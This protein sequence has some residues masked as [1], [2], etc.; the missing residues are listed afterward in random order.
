MGL[1]STTIPNLVNGVS[2]Q[3]YA[4]RLASQCERLVNGYPSVVE[5]LGKRPGSRY[6]GT[7]SSFNSDPFLHLIN[8]DKTEKY[9]VAIADGDL[10]VF[11]LQGTEK[12]VNFPDGKVY[13]TSANAV[14]GLKCMTV[15]DYTFVLNTAI[16]VRASTTLSPTRPY[17]ALVWIK[18]GAYGATYTLTVAGKAVSYKVPDGSNSSHSTNV[19]TDFI[20]TQLFNQIKSKLGG[21]WAVTRLGSTL[22]IRRT[23][24]VAFKVATDDSIGDKGIDALVTKSQRFSSLPARAVD[25]FTIEIVGDQSSSFDNYYVTYDSEGTADGAGVWKETLKGGEAIG[26]N[27]DTMPP[28]INP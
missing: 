26:L 6:L 8:R 9:V 25:G 14:T 22:H 15:A 24:G 23:S 20:A 18:Q 10:K 21:S 19:T 17:E 5:G 12:S 13:L 2:Q 28:C 11:D 16:T 1:V 3:P 27:A 4:L 7:I